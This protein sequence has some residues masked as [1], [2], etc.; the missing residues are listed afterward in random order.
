MRTADREQYETAIRGLRAMNGHLAAEIRNCTGDKR[1]P[2]Y[3][4]LDQL[5][6]EWKEL[7]SRNNSLIQL[8]EAILE[9]G[10]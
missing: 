3:G 4:V 1:V 7:M 5:M 10:P 2:R 6:D 9:H 8:Y